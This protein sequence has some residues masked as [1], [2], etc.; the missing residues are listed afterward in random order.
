MIINRQE[1]KIA[2]VD[3]SMEDILRPDKKEGEQENGVVDDFT[4]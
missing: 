1:R 3:F 4:D 2:T